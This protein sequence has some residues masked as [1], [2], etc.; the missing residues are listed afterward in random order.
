MIASLTIAAHELRRYFVSPLAWAC[1]AMVQ[2]ILGVVFWLL[3]AEFA[4]S[5]TGLGGN[6]GVADYI[7]GGLFGFSTIVL[8]MVIPL[9]TMR[10]FAEERASGS[11][12]LLLASPVSLI[13]LVLGKFLGLLG[14]LSVMLALIGAMPLSLLLGTDLDLGRIAAGLLGLFLMMAAFAS[15]G[16]F[17]SALTAQPVI[18][19]VGGFGLLML[20]WLTQVLSAGDGWFA[21]LADYMSLLSHFDNLRR[22]LFDS[23]DVL[24]YL[25]FSLA[26]LGLT[27]QRF[28]WERSA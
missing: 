6:A 20:L 19:A 1:L 23:T 12:E 25:L 9:L 18:A 8:L 10:S 21:P 15:A 3:L 14:F 5:Q 2:L 11:L 28:E 16:L 13:D 24:F 17:V 22:G 26:F 7:G 27:V 4:L